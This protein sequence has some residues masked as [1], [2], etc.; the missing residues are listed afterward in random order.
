MFPEKCILL[1]I[2]SVLFE[3][4][5]KIDAWGINEI[6]LAVQTSIRRCH[7]RKVNNFGDNYSNRE[8]YFPIIIEHIIICLFH[9]LCVNNA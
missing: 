9:G 7:L 8:I 3:L 4:R 5:I 2:L 1:E 6:R